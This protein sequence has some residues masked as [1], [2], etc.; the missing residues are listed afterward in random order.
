MDGRDAP[1]GETMAPGVDEE[2]NLDV[3][4]MGGRDRRGGFRYGTELKGSNRL[5]VGNLYF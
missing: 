1:P 5:R 4:P 3:D 2:D